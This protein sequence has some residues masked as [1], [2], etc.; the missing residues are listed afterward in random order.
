MQNPLLQMND[1][2]PFQAIK[3][4]HVE[5][6]VDAVLA[7][8]RAEVV[9]LLERDDGFSWF[10]LVEPLEALDDRLSRIWSPVS[11]MNAVVNNPKLRSAYEACLPKLS[12]YATEMGQNEQLYQAFEWIRNGAEYDTLNTAQQKVID[13]TL[14]DF[15]LSGVALPAEQKA[16]YK[17]LKSELSTLTTTFSNN[18]LDATNAWSKLITEESG[19]AGLPDSSK[20]ML[21]QAAEREGQQGWRVTLEFPSYFAVMAYADDR[22]LREEVYQAFVTRASDQG[23]DAGKWD[24]SEVMERILAI[25]HELAQLL[26]F[27]NYA[28]RS[29]TTKMAEEPQQVLDFL[30]D[31]AARSLALAQEELEEIRTFAREQHG[32]A[33]IQPWDITYYAEK[34]R[35]AKYAISQEDLKPYFP[36][37]RVISGL[38]EVV[39]RLYGLDIHEVEGV[40]TWHED[41]RFFEIYDNQDRLRGRFY[42]DLYARQN[43]RGGAWMDECIVRRV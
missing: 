39:K 37:K 26:G 16:R 18:L 19:V 24:N 28:E 3:P 7:E 40:S 33:L 13:N 14:R 43:K 1:L 31:L 30:R 25:R 6:A 2:P 5:P 38:F 8:N 17:E 35:Q 21:K 29:L 23:P 20:G 41:V 9:R 11:H 27:Q 34:L 15:R 4:E 10:T 12:D 36:E 32:M 22:A 42:L